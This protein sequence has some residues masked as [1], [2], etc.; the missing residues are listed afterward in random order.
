MAKN[1]NDR[2]FVQVLEESSL[3]SCTSILADTQTGVQYLYHG[4]GNGGGMTVLVDSEGKP[5]LYRRTP[6]A[7]EY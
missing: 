3:L 5:L 2:R 4:S 6:D 1:K 7:P